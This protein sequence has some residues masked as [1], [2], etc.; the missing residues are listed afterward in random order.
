MF[1]GEGL[2][3]FPT[4]VIYLAERSVLNGRI[5]LALE[6]EARCLFLWG[7]PKWM[8]F[9]SLVLWLILGRSGVK[10]LLVFGGFKNLR[11]ALGIACNVPKCIN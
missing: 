11:C 2:F 1:V 9:R 4:A 3:V 7:K 5:L 10:S 6:N 8:L